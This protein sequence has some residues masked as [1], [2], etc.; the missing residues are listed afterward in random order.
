[1]TLKNLPN[2]IRALNFHSLL[3]FLFR[4]P[5]KSL[6]SSFRIN[7]FRGN[8]DKMNNIVAIGN[9]LNIPLRAEVDLVGYFFGNVDL[10]PLVH[11]YNIHL[12]VLPRKNVPQIFNRCK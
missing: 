4:E 1:M 2:L 11:A 6:K 10:I 5:V 12:E 3:A 7:R 9:N 8:G